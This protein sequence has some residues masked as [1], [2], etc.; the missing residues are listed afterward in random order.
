MITTS[1]LVQIQ[2]VYVKTPTW[3]SLSEAVE[4][5][6]PAGGCFQLFLL[7]LKIN[8]W[9]RCSHT[10]DERTRWL[11]EIN[12]SFVHPIWDWILNGWDLFVIKSKRIRPT[13]HRQTCYLSHTEPE[14]LSQNW[15]TLE[16]QKK[17]LEKE[18]RNF[19]DTGE[20]SFGCSLWSQQ[21]PGVMVAWRTTVQS[22]ETSEA[23]QSSQRCTNRT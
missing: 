6:P 14:E 12:P 22:R 18:P 20:S 11:Q 3:E 1:N 4:R 7:V 10:C 16:D 13:H 15:G 8:S 9:K 17:E 2:R 5:A 23:N 19:T 21:S